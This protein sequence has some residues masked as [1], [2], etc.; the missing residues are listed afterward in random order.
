MLVEMPLA[1]IP[2]DIDWTP[3]QPA[4]V[5]RGEFTALRRVILLPQAPRIYARVLM[6]PIVGEA[7]V[8]A[9]RAFVFDLEGVANRFRLIACEGPQLPGDPVVLVDGAGQGAYQLAT[10]GWGAP[11]LKLRRGQF[12]TVGEQLL[13]LMSDVVA[14]AL[15][16]AILR[17]KPYLRL[18]PA[19]N[20]R[21]EVLRPYAVMSMSDPR[22]GWRVSIGQRYGFSFDCEEAF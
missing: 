5:N 4:Q 11:G 1:P 15:G 8:L 21:I 3:E 20:Q 9:W 17:F 22:F 19:D 10:K 16:R 13:A 14:D 6:P 7:R 2:A 12:V 18:A